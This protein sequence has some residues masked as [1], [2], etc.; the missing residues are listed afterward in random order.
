[1]G[2]GAPDNNQDDKFQCQASSPSWVSYYELLSMLGL[3]SSERVAGLDL[4]VESNGPKLWMGDRIF[5]RSEKGC[6]R[7]GRLE[8]TSFV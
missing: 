3:R 6:T 7:V 8:P 5:S 2:K 4:P 1:M